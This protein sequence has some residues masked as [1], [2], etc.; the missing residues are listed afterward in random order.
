MERRGKSLWVSNKE[1]GIKDWT[2]TLVT[3]IKSAKE[4]LVPLCSPHTVVLQMVKNEKPPIKSINQLQE[5]KKTLVKVLINTTCA[6]RFARD[7]VRTARE[8]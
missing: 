5:R 3:K 7:P 4:R 8:L 1:D 6:R 2:Y